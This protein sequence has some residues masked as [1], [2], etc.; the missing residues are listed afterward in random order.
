MVKIGSRIQ[1]DFQYLA[2]GFVCVSIETVHEKD[3]ERYDNR[4]DDSQ[5]IEFCTGS[6]TDSHSEKHKSNIAC[7]FHGISETDDGKRSYEREGASNIWS[8]D[9][10]DNGN[11]DGH[12]H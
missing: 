7:L 3:D 5:K 4:E 6:H 1:L 11:D 2:A 8:Y 10:H 12:D 9:H